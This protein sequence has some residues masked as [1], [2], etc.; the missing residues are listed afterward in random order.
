M[1]KKTKSKKVVKTK[2]K[3]KKKNKKQIKKKA[4]APALPTK[5]YK[6]EFYSSPKQINSEFADKI[7]ELEKK[8]K[9]PIVLLWH[10]NLK[11]NY[12]SF[13][14]YNYLAFARNIRRLRGR[15]PVAVLLNSPG[16][17]GGDAFKLASL[18]KKHCGGFTVIVPYYA[19]SAATL[20]S[21]GADKII[22]SRFGADLLNLGP[23]M[24]KC[25]TATK[26]RTSLH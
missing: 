2:K 25:G 1:A 9:K 4:V 17:T 13:N 11:D 6:A 3:A 26:K 23:L 24:F 8:L 22:M 15:E 10:G 20:F 16:G 7:K 18:L 5:K 12:S 21:L 19:K 14:I